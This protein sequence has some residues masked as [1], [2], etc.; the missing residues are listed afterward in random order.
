MIYKWLAHRPWIYKWSGYYSSL[1]HHHW[2]GRTAPARTK[3]VVWEVEREAMPGSA[4]LAAEVGKP[5]P[6][7]T[8]AKPRAWVEEGAAHPSRVRSVL[9]AG[10]GG[11]HLRDLVRQSV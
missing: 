11:A 2:T 3:S 4:R 6:H 8:R 5:A 1:S 9:W 10:E 7:T